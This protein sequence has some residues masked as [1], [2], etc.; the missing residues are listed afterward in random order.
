[1]LSEEIFGLL[2]GVV[3]LAAVIGYLIEV[4]RHAPRY[5]WLELPPMK[6][7]EKPREAGGGVNLPRVSAIRPR[8][9]APGS[10]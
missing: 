9:P 1:M 8:E 7:R 6:P 4:S 2:I 10:R 3:A 5:G